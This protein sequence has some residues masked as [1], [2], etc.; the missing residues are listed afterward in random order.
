M[1]AMLTSLVSLLT[2]PTYSAMDLGGCPA[3]SMRVGVSISLGMTAIL[4]HGI[5]ASEGVLFSLCLT[6]QHA[7]RSLTVTDIES[8]L[9][10]DGDEPWFATLNPDDR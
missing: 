8:T 7:L 4:P 10:N 6:G 5:C 9:N 2:R 1:C 3:A